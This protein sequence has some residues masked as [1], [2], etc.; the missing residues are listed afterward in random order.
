MDRL[1]ILAAI[2]A[3]VIVVSAIARALL[4]RRHAIS[5]IDLAD[6]AGAEG[7]VATVVFTSLFCH[8]CKQ[9]IDALGEGDLRPYA[10]DIG[11]RPDAAARYKI[12]ATPR[13]AV[14]RTSD[15]V[16]LREFDHYTPRQ[17]DLDAISRL[18]SAA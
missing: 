10:V 7:A 17:H 12:N 14:V 15:G 13:V 2:V 16:V 1:L 9:W 4:K 8:G 11:A 5:R 18:I 3:T 6:I